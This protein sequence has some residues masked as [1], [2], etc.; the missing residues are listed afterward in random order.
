MKANPFA[1]PSIDKNRHTDP[2]P[3]SFYSL[4][5]LLLGAQRPCKPPRHP[6]L[7][8]FSRGRMACFVLDVNGIDKM[9]GTVHESS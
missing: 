5:L 2:R 7:E 9:L 1:V 8:K 6:S 3:S 4:Q